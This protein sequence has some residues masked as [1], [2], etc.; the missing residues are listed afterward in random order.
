[1][2]KDNSQTMRIAFWIVLGLAFTLSSLALTSPQATTQVATVTPT[3][4]ADT[5]V[6]STEARNEAGSTDGI[7]LVAAL[8]VSIVIVP[9]LLKRQV[10]SNGKRKKTN[11]S[12][13]MG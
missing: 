1:M 8:I 5:I 4:L 9:I 13:W 10:W 7:M 6:S 11:P 12:V 3:A 2:N